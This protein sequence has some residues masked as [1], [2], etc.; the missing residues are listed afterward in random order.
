MFNPLPDLGQTRITQRVERLS[1][2]TCYPFRGFG[3]NPSESWLEETELSRH[4]YCSCPTAPQA[5]VVSGLACA[6]EVHPWRKACF[7]IIGSCHLWLPQD[8]RYLNALSPDLPLF[9]CKVY[10]LHV[11]KFGSFNP[12]HLYSSNFI[13]WSPIILPVSMIILEAES[14]QSMHPLTKRRRGS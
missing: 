4:T 13:Y 2:T 12:P 6:T 5:P 14:E 9:V 1:R 7:C 3:R 8:F 11:R 10:T